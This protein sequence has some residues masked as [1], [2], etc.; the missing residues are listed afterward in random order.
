MPG[1]GKWRLIPLVALTLAPLAAQNP[2]ETPAAPPPMRIPFERI[3]PETTLDMMAVMG[4]GTTADAVWALAAT[5]A[6]VTRIDLDGPGAGPA[7]ALPGKPCGTIAAAFGAVW[8]PVCGDQP[9]LVRIDEKTSELETVALSA[10]VPATGSDSPTA[11]MS[12]ATGVGS[13]WL[14]APQSGLLLR[15]DP[16]TRLPVADVYLPKMSADLAFGFEALW[17]AA[18]IANRA[19]RLNPHTNAVTKSIAAGKPASRIAVSDDAVWVLSEADGTVIRIDPKTDAVGATI[20]VAEALAGGRIAAGVGSVW[21]SAAGL[22]LARIDPRT[23]RVVQMFTGDAAVAAM[24]HGHD[25]LWLAVSD[26]LWRVDP[27]FLEALRP[28]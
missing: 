28:E 2:P 11:P 5:P 3:K 18:G 8:I 24:V 16:D 25:S 12:V 21:I 17:V 22:P 4:I 7:I 14:L 26:R 6:S 20:D 1:A 19:I 23:N 15:I 9:S 10:L 13:V 27:K